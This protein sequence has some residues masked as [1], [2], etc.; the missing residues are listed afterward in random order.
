M[1]MRRRG[2]LSDW[3]FC[4]LYASPRFASG[5]QES[6]R[7]KFRD[8]IMQATNKSQDRENENVRAALEHVRS[9]TKFT[10]LKLGGGQSYGSSGG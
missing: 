5:F 6:L 10:K 1:G 7:S 2:Y 9:N 3:K 4:T 8:R